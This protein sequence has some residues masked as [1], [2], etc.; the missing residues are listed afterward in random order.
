MGHR[1]YSAPRHG[2]LAY[3]PR[4]RAKE[5]LPSVRY[6]PSRDGVKGLM[7]FIAYKAGTLTLHYVDDLPGSPTFGT[8]VQTAA[9][10]LAAPPMYI[11]GVVLMGEENGNLIELGRMYADNLPEALLKKVRGISP[12][13][14]KEEIKSLLDKAVEVRAIVASF[15]S[16]AGLSQKRPFLLEIKVGGEV[17]SALEYVMSK[18]GSKISASEVFTPGLYVD[19][20]GVTKGHGF[21][22]V[23][24]RFGVKI[25]PRKQ[26]KTRRAVGAIGG[27]KP[28]YVTRFVPRAGQM[29]YH[30]RTEFNKRVMAVIDDGAK[31]TPSG[32]FKHFTVL[33]SP[34]IVVLGS[35]FGTPKRP[36]VLRM[37]AK[38]PSH[39][40]S[41]PKIVSYIY[42][43]EVLAS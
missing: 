39:S 15:P 31:L 36:V 8:E 37:P 35:V 20:I 42:G 2:S 29:G 34:C 25:L 43:G 7:G 24:K 28:T 9:T 38:P 16:E 1:K 41:S 33:K 30:R 40:V 27:R 6:W 5:L 12:G 14:G 18:L 22:G 19:V 21:E 10:V 26:R 13:A 32:G 11:I 23:V 17:R 3:S 4:K